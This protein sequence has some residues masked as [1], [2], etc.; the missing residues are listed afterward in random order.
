MD[1]FTELLESFSKLKKRKLKLIVENADPQATAQQELAAA[2]SQNPPPTTAAPYIAQAARVPLAIFN[3]KKGWK[4]A[5]TDANGIPQGGYN[6]KFIDKDFDRFV[7]YFSE[8]DQTQQ[9]GNPQQDPMQQ[10]MDPMGMPMLT[11]EQMEVEEAFNEMFLGADATLNGI[12]NP[13]YRKGKLWDNLD[14]FREYLAGQNL[15]SVKAQLQGTKVTVQK[16]PLTG[17]YMMVPVPPNDS[18][19]IDV[20]NSIKD[21]TNVLKKDNATQ[22][23][24]TRLERN[25]RINSDGTVSVL[26]DTLESGLVF[27]DVN[28]FL[29]NVVGAAFQKFGIKRKIIDVGKKSKERLNNSI[30]TVFEDVLPVFALAQ[31]KASMEAIG[32]PA[33][34]KIDRAIKTAFAVVKDKLKKLAQTHQEWTSIF[35]MSAQEPQEVEVMNVIRSFLG[36]Q[37]AGLMKSIFRL[38]KDS[39]AV[40]NPDLIVATGRNTGDGVRHDVA[41]LYGNFEAAKIALVNMGYSEEE[42]ASRGMV[43]ADTI[44]NI[45]A[46]NP[47]RYNEYKA[48]GLITPGSQMFSLNVSLKNYANVDGITFGE[49]LAGSNS[50]FIQGQSNDGGKFFQSFQK[51]T[52]L[53]PQAHQGAKDYDNYLNKMETDVGEIPAKALVRKGAGTSLNRS[54]PLKRFAES[55][56]KTLRSNYSHQELAGDNEVSDIKAIVH[57]YINQKDRKDSLTEDKLR[58]YASTFLKNKKLQSDLR[59]GKPEA[60]NYLLMKLYNTAGSVDEGMTID[61]RELNTGRSFNLIQSEV[62]NEVIQS[63]NSEDGEWTY[64][65]NGNSITF[66]NVRDPSVTLVMGESVKPKSRDGTAD[67]GFFTRTGVTL[68]RAGVDRYSR[69]RPNKMLKA[70]E[71]LI[72]EQNKILLSLLNEKQLSI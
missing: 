19:L 12:I 48:L 50:A 64:T 72:R 26:T 28:G 31:K 4:F 54:L 14:T 33:A 38:S 23:E 10:G 11:P 15:F 49:S 53:T 51:L 58:Q 69:R 25:F 17:N 21:L 63:I 18:T 29:S 40:R 6:Q 30:K 43:K 71:S 37:G 52:G 39:V 16:D 20:T 66:S 36:E 65:V 60:K 57:K 59:K 7:G 61:C 32:H 67:T 22:D 1:Y 13:Q 42:I 46:N 70:I 27:R 56:A 45:L 2:Q 3:T 24:K 9:Q 41:E 5:P 44:E 62:V 8:G 47:E 68:S 35:E 34:K 55:L